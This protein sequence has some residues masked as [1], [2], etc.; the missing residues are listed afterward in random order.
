MKQL[1]LCSPTPSQAGAPRSMELTL[2]SPQDM[3]KLCGGRAKAK[4]ARNVTGKNY[5]VTPAAAKNPRRARVQALFSIT[6]ILGEFMTATAVSTKR[7]APA[8]W[9]VVAPYVEGHWCG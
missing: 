6:E 3:I 5:F 1:R 9:A 7:R 2:L 4:F 8:K